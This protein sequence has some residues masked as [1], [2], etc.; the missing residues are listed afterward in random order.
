MVD[1]S[2]PVRDV[3]ESGRLAHLV[4]VNADG[5]PHVTIVW[6]GLDGDEIVIGKL[7]VDQKVRNIRRDPRVA[8][9]IEAEGE[10]YGMQHYLVVE[11]TAR[12]TE[13]GAPALLRD[14][15]QRY[16][17]PGTEFP[18]MPDPPEGYVIRI[19]PTKVRGMGPWGTT[20]G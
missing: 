8:L 16:I 7:A 2:S 6:V 20:L 1:I 12:V 17:G 19:R 15:A 10:Q 18:P 14:L 3:I 11:G 9:S 5:S 13:G 4:T